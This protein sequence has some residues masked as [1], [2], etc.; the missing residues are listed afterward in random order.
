MAP[1]ILQFFGIIEHMKSVKQV[2]NA[3]L[4][5]RFVRSLRNT[6]LRFLDYYDAISKKNQT[7]TPPRSLHYV[8]SG[9][10][11]AVG[12]E[13]YRYFVELGGLSPGDVVLDIGCGT[14][15][16]A[17]PLSRYLTSGSYTGFDLSRSAITWC[18]QHISPAWPRF[19]FVHAD[20]YNAEYNESGAIDAAA[21]R[22]P[23]I[24]ETVDFAFATSVFT[25]IRTA[26]VKN[27]LRETQRVLKCNARSFATFF[28]L[29]DVARAGMAD[30]SSSALFDTELGGC[31]TTD[32]KTPERAIAYT[33]E[34]IRQM[35]DEAGLRIVEPIRYGSW[36]G[37]SDFLSF[38]DI[39]VARKE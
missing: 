9:D 24:D 8:G 14:G 37:R 10:F 31:F 5:R 3:V 35:Y 20:I 22:F 23:C 6:G 7:L 19:R 13:F 30:G 15:R 4:P 33:E 26:E 34:A 1:L 38:Q 36:S 11:E 39:V 18:Q 32:P 16:M 2:A 25:H 12:N 27:Y 17:Q 29:N 28:L 21:F